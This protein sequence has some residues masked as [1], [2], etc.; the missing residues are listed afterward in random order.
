MRWGKRNRAAT[1]AERVLQAGI[2][3]ARHET[4][5]AATPI[6]FLRTRVEARV[7][8]QPAKGSIM[9]NA[10]T[11]VTG[12]RK[13]MV[14]TIVVAVLL[15]VA[16]LVPFSYTRTVGY[17]V[18][19]SGVEA[20]TMASVND[21]TEAI[22]ALGYEGISYQA[23]QCGDKFEYVVRG[24]PN[25]SAAREVN[26]AFASLTGAK[27]KGKIEPIEQASSGSLYA[28]VKQ[29]MTCEDICVDIN[30]DMTDAEIEAMVMQRLTEQGCDPQGVK[31]RT[32]DDGRKE[33]EI[34]IGSGECQ[35]TQ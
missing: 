17:Q 30:A 14:P 23:S 24:L 35:P 27:E 10:I 1:E 31:V 7:S 34:S 19:F 33:I 12:H 11:H 16:V 22:K 8:E 18:T 4:P 21:I 26:V 5:P 29:Q 9:A 15:L 28:Q 25:L 2:E 20:S 6:P 13:W 32:L 3:A